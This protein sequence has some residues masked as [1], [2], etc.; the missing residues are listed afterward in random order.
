MEK[1]IIVR[2]IY[3]N[4]RVVIVN[5]FRVILAIGNVGYVTF[6]HIDIN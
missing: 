3:I 2:H 5:M 4:V 6:I 1:P